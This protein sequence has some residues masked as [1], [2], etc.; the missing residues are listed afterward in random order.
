MASAQDPGTNEQTAVS[1][2]PVGDGAPE[3]SIKDRNSAT[4]PAADAT[5]SN[6]KMDAVM[7]SDVSSV[8]EDNV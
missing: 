8:E 5:E 3:G 7:Q 6:E 1:N 2:A 4:V